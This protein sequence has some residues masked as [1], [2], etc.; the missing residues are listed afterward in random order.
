MRYVYLTMGVLVTATFP[1]AFA[2]AMFKSG[3]TGFGWLFVGAGLLAALVT[4]IAYWRISK[5]PATSGQKE[6]TC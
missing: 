1:G 4:G 5:P 3:E 6:K 2:L